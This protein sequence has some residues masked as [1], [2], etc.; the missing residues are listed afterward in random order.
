MPG[1]ASTGNILVLYGHGAVTENT[2]DFRRSDATKINLYSWTRE[3]IPVWDTQIQLAADDAI[4]NGTIRSSYATVNSSRIG[5]TVMK[6]LV[7]GP[8][9]GLR[10][11]DIPI[12]YVATPIAALNA[13]VHHN[14]ATIAASTRM[15]LMVDDNNDVLFFS[16]IIA[17]PNFSGRSFDILWCAC[18]SRYE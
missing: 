3:A 15:V 9:D 10:L 5:G 18:K 11:P 13:T 17:D 1:P 6:D 2:F 4:A 12:G 16:G 14:G 8:P 7:I